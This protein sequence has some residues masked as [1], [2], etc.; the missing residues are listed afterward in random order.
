[1]LR[2]SL[3]AFAVA[4]T[5]GA[6]VQSAGTSSDVR[7][8]LSKNSTKIDTAHD[9]I[10][11]PDALQRGRALVNGCSC[12]T[13]GTCN[14]FVCPSGYLHR[15]NAAQLFCDDVA[16][17]NTNYNTCC[18]SAALCNTMACPSGYL[19]RENAAQLFCDDVACIDTDYN[20]CCV[21]D[22]PPPTLACPSGSRLRE[23]A[24]QLFDYNT[25]CA[26][27]GTCASYSCPTGLELK[28]NADDLWCASSMCTDMDVDECCQYS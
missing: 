21:F 10:K 25:F 13:Q 22:G 4:A 8:I 2:V 14:T 15:E 16:C 6:P 5:I 17:I 7:K 3:V 26:F 1:M 24:A 18:V 9:N 28:P 23:N 19:H 11:D 27:E 20:T 12:V